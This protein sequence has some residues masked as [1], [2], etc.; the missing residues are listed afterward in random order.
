MPTYVYG[1][2]EDRTHERVEVVHSMFVD[3]ELF[4]MT[5]QARMRRVPMGGLAVAFDAGEILT[6]WMTENYRRWRG[7]KARLN[8]VNRVGTPMSKINRRMR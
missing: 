3:P 6:G 4:C 5:C 7:G 2:S 8:E 1:C